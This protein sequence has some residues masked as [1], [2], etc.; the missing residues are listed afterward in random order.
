MWGAIAKGLVKL[1]LWCV[2]HPQVLDTV[3]TQVI[4]TKAKQ[5]AS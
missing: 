1:A 3:V 4:A 5:G 2:E